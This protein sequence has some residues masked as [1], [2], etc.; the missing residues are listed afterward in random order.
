[1]SPARDY[2]RWLREDLRLTRGGR[3]VFTAVLLVGIAGLVADVVSDDQHGDQ[4]GGVLFVFIGLV[5]GAVVGADAAFR[6]LREVARRSVD[7]P[8]EPS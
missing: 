3:L 7:R 8:T 5:L 4:L 6:R 1:V 2:W